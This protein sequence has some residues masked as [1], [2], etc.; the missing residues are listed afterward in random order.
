MVMKLLSAQF[1]QEEKFSGSLRTKARACSKVKY[2]N[3]NNRLGPWMKI[4]LIYKTRITA[5]KWVISIR[6]EK[7]ISLPLCLLRVYYLIAQVKEG[8]DRK[9][10]RVSWP[11]WLGFLFS[12]RI[13]ITT[14]Q[15]SWVMKSLT[16]VH[17]LTFFSWHLYLTTCKYM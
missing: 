9:K 2:G 12:L 1:H 15:S 11:E 6:T 10:L 3:C 5:E 8:Q 7:V 14:P 16:C 13:T 17:F 4:P